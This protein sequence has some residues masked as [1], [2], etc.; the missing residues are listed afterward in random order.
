MLRDQATDVVENRCYSI[1]EK[2]TMIRS[3]I[4]GSRSVAAMRMPTAEQL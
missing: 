2:K 3:K 4:D 1:K